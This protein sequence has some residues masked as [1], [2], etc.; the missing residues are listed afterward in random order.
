MQAPVFRSVSQMVRE[1]GNVLPLSS[2]VAVIIPI[3]PTLIAAATKMLVPVSPGISTTPSCE[4]V[5]LTAARSG[6]GVA[7][8]DNRNVLTPGKLTV[9]CVLAQ[10]KMG[11]NSA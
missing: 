2:A 11:A 4:G 1:T 7:E 3:A 9:G 6:V 10:A 8:A 5:T